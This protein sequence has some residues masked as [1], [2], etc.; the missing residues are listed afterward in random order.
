MHLYGTSFKET[1]VKQLYTDA[2]GWKD[3]N[4][5]QEKTKLK[6]IKIQRDTPIKCYI[7][8][9]NSQLHIIKFQAT[10]AYYTTATNFFISATWSEDLTDN[11]STSFT[12][13]YKTSGS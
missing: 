3:T 8:F 12:C 1:K 13:M 2:K 4:K 9:N 10:K 5:K 6:G 11:V 7:S